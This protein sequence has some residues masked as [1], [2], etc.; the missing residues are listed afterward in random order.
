V[1][2]DDGFDGGVRFDAW[3]GY[4]GLPDDRKRD[5]LPNGPFIFELI[6]LRTIREVN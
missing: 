1:D 2:S 6:E 5:P 4:I 3:S